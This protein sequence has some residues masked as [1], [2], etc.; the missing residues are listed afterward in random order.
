M[1]VDYSQTINKFTEL[2]G[3]PLPRMQDVIHNVLQHNIFTTLDLKSGCHRVELRKDDRIYKVFQADGGFYQF[4]RMSFGLKNAVLCFQR[5]IDD[6]IRENKCENTYTC[7]K[8]ITI[9]GKTQEEHDTSLQRFLKVAKDC[10]LTSND[11]RST[12]SSKLSSSGKSI[13]RWLERFAA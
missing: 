8:N 12:Y 1:C 13:F 3:Y 9:C 5:L 4:T 10:N 6:I 11:D 2:D 7:S